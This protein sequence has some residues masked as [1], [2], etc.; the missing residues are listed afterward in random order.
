MVRLKFQFQYGAIGSLIM[1][2]KQT[3]EI[4]FQFQYGAI[5]RYQPV[6]TTV[7]LKKVSIPVWCDWERDCECRF[8]L[9]IGS[10]NSS[11]VRLGGLTN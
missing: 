2:D 11:M 7:M 8:R 3:I 6:A 4:L 10:F 5:G 9:K 1:N